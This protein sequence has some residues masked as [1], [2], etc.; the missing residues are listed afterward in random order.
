MVP[1]SSH[2]PCP[3]RFTVCCCT[4]SHNT[5]IEWNNTFLANDIAWKLTNI[6]RI[7]HNAVLSI[8]KSHAWLTITYIN[9][10]SHIVTIS[11]DWRCVVCIPIRSQLC[12]N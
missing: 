10:R 12:G 4:K 7:I 3:D 11:T 2:I 9:P 5:N 6:G 1:I 8:V